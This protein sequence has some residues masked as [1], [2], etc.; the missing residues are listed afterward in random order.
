M[1]FIVILISGFILMLTATFAA[2]AQEPK[3]LRRK[4]S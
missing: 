3:N 2:F 4:R 1:R